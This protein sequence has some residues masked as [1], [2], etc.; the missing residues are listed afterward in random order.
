MN[1]K[2]GDRLCVGS[3]GVNCQFCVLKKNITACGDLSAS[4]GKPLCL[5][6]IEKL[7]EREGGG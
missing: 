6:A 2:F 3:E 7:G 1:S 4:L 5:I